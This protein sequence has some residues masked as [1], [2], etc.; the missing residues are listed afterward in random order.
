MNSSIAQMTECVLAYQKLWLES[1]IDDKTAVED[2]QN[3]IREIDP[4][5]MERDAFW[6]YESKYDTL[7]SEI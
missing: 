1:K 5:C 4:A 3:K 6:W 7:N 2:L